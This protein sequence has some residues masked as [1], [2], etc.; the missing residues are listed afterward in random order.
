MMFINIHMSIDIVFIK[1]N[2]AVTKKKYMKKNWFF[3]IFN[4]IIVSNYLS[5]DLDLNSYTKGRPYGRVATLEACNPEVVGSSPT[6]TVITVT[7]TSPAYSSH[8]FGWPLAVPAG[9]ASTGGGGKSY[10]RQERGDARLEA[11]Q[12]PKD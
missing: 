7:R 6:S 8:Q 4:T 12:D 5:A 11:K 2:M 9:V 3:S 1:N 10:T